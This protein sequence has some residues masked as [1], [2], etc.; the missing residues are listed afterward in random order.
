MM[1][2]PVIILLFLV[3]RYAR[4]R[5]L[6]R[7]GE[8]DV[9]GQLMPEVSG[10][11]PALKLLLSILGLTFLVLTLA[12]PQF[13]SR[14]EE[15]KRKGVELIIALDVSNS[16]LAEDI[17][18]NRLERAK[19]SIERLVAQLQNDRIGL[20]IFAGEAYVQVPLTDDYLSVKMF[21]QTIGPESIS[22]QGTAIGSAIGLAMNSFSP[23]TEKSRVLIIMTDGENHEDDPVAMATEA[24][25]KGII[26]HT[27]GIGNPEGVPIPLTPG[28][29]NRAYRKDNQGNTVISRLDE[30]TLQQV[31]SAGNGKYVRAAGSRMGLNGLYDEI[32][33][34]QKEEMEARVYSE[35]DERFQYMAGAALLFLL[36]EFFVLERKN[37]FFTN[38]NLFGSVKEK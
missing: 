28:S 31:A 15:V 25:S 2:I 3:F 35:F 37:R 29:Q 9:T 33:K 20:I 5:A 12:G 1:A 24:A 21:I 23:D 22:R 38:M 4:R 14:L 7:F 13:G 6:L 30:K 32:N 10:L 8:Q 19:M 18:P 27:L 11:K 16:M 36:L 26:V 34:M 17:E